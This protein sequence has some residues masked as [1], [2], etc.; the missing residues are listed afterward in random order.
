MGL[1][2]AQVRTPARDRAAM[3]ARLYGIVPAGSTPEYE[4][5]TPMVPDL[6]AT[7]DP[8]RLVPAT[9]ARVESGAVLWCGPE[10]LRVRA[11]SGRNIHK[12]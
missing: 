4:A 2:T 6:I 7:I 3:C 11:G 12:Y 10:I 8:S 1:T 5:E 9:L